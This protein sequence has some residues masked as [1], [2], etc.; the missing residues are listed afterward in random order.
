MPDVIDASDRSAVVRAAELILDG[1]IVAFPTETVYGLG[2]L[3]SSDRA[4]GR[5]YAAKGRP[6]S[7]PLI[8]HVADRASAA[9]FAEFDERADRLAERFWPGPLTLVLPLKVPSAISMVMSAGL[10]TV[11]V[12]VPAHPVAR[13]LLGAVELPVAAPSANRSGHVSPTT[14]AHVASEFGNEVS[15]VL[16]GG[17]CEVGVES[18]VVDLSDPDRVR[19]LRP[20]AIDR[21]AL[22]RLIGPLCAPAADGPVRAPGM[23]LRHYSPDTAIRLDATS[24]DA[25]EA[26]LAFGPKPLEG[27]ATALNLSEAGNLDEAASRLYGMMRQLDQSRARCIAVMPV[28]AHGLGEA[29]NDRLRRAAIADGKASAA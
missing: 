9:I 20:G 6:S 28:P 22:E 23:M 18:T 5:V 1:G 2:A 13:A 14:A 11:A 7:N 26:L 15:L 17:S 16:D 4:I 25:D 12:R 3:A 21:Q 8:A 29:I 19:L 24:V 10:S 27:A